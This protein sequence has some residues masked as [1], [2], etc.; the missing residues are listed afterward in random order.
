MKQLINSMLKAG[1]MFIIMTFL[2]S[3]G[4]QQQ[5]DYSKELKPIFDK[6]YEVWKTG[7]VDELDAIIDPSFMRHA[8]AGSSAKSLDELKKV[9]TEFKNTFSDV[10]LVSE[11]EIFTE[12]KFAGRW[13][14]TG[15]TTGSGERSSNGKSVSQWGINIIHFKDGKIIEEW[16]GFD[17]VP[18]LEQLGFVM[19]PPATEKK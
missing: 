18:M 8:D 12:N 17:N 5:P 1:S 10:K 16:D 3:T 9:I 7:N 19:T 11:E 13:S 2:I 15:K 6:Y 14:F 4:C